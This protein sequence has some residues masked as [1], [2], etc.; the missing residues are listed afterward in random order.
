MNKNE[1]KKILYSF[2]LKTMKYA[3]IIKS[4]KRTLAEKITAVAM[5]EVAVSQLQTQLSHK[6][7]TNFADGG[8][9]GGKCNDCNPLLNPTIGGE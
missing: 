1:K 7:A 5:Q 2:M 6:P 4:D 9:V 8:V 3:Q